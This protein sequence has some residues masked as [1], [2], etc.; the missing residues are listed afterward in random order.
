NGV[1]K[2]KL[3]NSVIHTSQGYGILA[4]NSSLYAE[5]CLIVECGAENLM[6]FEGG[7]YRIYDCTIGTYG[8][9]FISHSEHV[10]VGLLNYFP[11]S[12]H[13][14]TA[15]ALDAELRNCIVYGSL[16]D[17]IIISRKGDHP[18]EVRIH[19]SLLKAGSGLPDFVEGQ[20]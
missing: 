8:G 6:A 12:E 19:H 20:S 18:A 11:I 16:K 17:E 3:T 5:N 14:Y 13:E 7:R 2:L 10:S 15:A 4:F 9:R 1:P